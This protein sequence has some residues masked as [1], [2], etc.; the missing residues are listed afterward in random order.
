MNKSEYRNPK[1]E[2]NSNNKNSKLKIVSSFVLRISN[3][4]FQSGQSLIEIILAIALSAILLP[5]LLTGLVS[6]RQGKAQQ[7]QRTQAVYFLNE[8][9]DAVRSVREKGWATFAVNGTY[10]PV[11]SGSSWA[12]STGSATVNGLTQQ[13]DIGD[14]YRATTGEI[15]TSG[16][17]LDPSS[18]KVDISISWGQPYI[19]TVSASLY[20]TRY[21]DNNSFTQTS[22]ADFDVGT[23]SGTTVTDISGGEVTLGAGGHGDWCAPGDYILAQ[24]D[25]PKSGTANAISAYE[26]R[27]IAGTG[28]NSSGVS[29][30][31]V[32][33]TN[34]NPPVP[35]LTGTFDGY[36]TNNVFIDGNYAYLATDT[37]SKE[38]VIVNLTTHAEVGYFDTPTNSDAT[39]V[40]VTGTKGYVTAGLYLYMFDLSSQS[41]SRPQVGSGYFFLGLATSVV[42]NGNYAYVSLASSPIELQIID[43]SNSQSFQNTGW[44]DVNGTDGKRVFINSSATRAYLATSQDASKRE[45]FII[46]ISQK[47]GARPTIGNYEA[48]GMNPTSLSVVPGNRAIL[49]GSGAEEYQVL[50][51]SN[52]TNPTRCGGMQVDSGIRGVSGVIEQD[53]DVYSYIV[54]GDASAEFKI[55]EGGPGGQY[56]SSGTFISGPFDAGYST[57][58]NRFDVSVNRPNVSDIQF[59]VAVAPAVSGNCSA[60]IFNF[61]GPDASTSAYFTTSVTSEIQTFNFAMPPSINPG[62]CFKYKAYFSTT[63][64]LSTPIFYDMTG[65]YSP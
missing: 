44:A 38:V 64:P 52:E 58:F 11:I 34:T 23:K 29:L 28:E 57:A 37:N 43:I 55:I 59:Q 13:V 10:H 22:V 32:T 40:F 31:D 33:I 15:V 46:D 30:A 9:V 50:N 60:A 4:K 14:V 62:R 39:S 47:T 7:A 20:I 12:M 45:F 35:T 25:L 8:T 48:N 21:L 17:S 24:L 19:S 2:T 26:G 5:A 41:G 3:F 56:A 18:K 54:T 61:V 65:N 63:D 36:K 6:S 53:G 1:P 42:V 49:V 16:G 51:I 27:A